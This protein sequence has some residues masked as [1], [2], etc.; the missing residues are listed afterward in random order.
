[1]ASSCIPQLEAPLEGDPA[2]HAELVA[3]LRRLQLGHALARDGCELPVVHPAVGG[4]AVGVA[5]GGTVLPENGAVRAKW[6]QRQ[7]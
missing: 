6:I 5:A 1:M 3:V 2:L 7:S 4:R